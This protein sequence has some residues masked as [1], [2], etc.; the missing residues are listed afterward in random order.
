[1][2]VATELL[3]ADDA[4]R[5][6]MLRERV[7]ALS[8]T[9]REQIISDCTGDKTASPRA[10][11]SVREAL[12]ERWPSCDQVKDQPRGLR[13]D[14]L[15]RI[16]PRSFYIYGFAYDNDPVV[17]V[18][19]A[20]APDGT[21]IELDGLA[22]RHAH[23]DADGFYAAGQRRRES[24]F[25]AF[26][27]TPRDQL[28]DGWLVTM[29]NRNGVGLE[30]RAPHPITEPRAAC[31]IILTH[32][33]HDRDD[34]LLAIHTHRAIEALNA[35]RRPPVPDLGGL[36]AK[37]KSPAISIVIP[38]FGRI[39]L[40]EHQL[41]AFADD[42]DLR[43]VELICVLDS[44]ELANEMRGKGQQLH[45]L[46]HLP[47][48]LMLLRENRGF[49]TACNVG[50]NAARGRRIV[51]MHSDVVPK[52]HGWLTPMSD[53]L[54]DDVGVVGATLLYH[55]ESI[56][57]AGYRVSADGEVEQPR[58]G[59]HKDLAVEPTPIDAVSAACMMV[60]RD[61]FVDVGGMCD[62]FVD[63]EYEDVDLCR[64]LKARGLRCHI[65]S[66]AQLYHL[67]G[68][69]RPAKQR[70][71]A[72]PYNKWLFSHRIRSRENV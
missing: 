43:D 49:A 61:A 50:A 10:V 2:S 41:A 63:G 69:S 42:P 3:A 28:N 57:H 27:T 24:G 5:R 12:R 54:R 47:V 36:L 64:R 48:M 15:I 8:A 22:F 32:F 65:A 39:D 18:L 51:F 37:R 59:L 38:V 35:T 1:M 11:F 19:E 30:A 68:Q 23:D 44:P 14:G 40:L 4:T 55:D 25:I 31:N 58:K 52:S 62:Q 33:R 9:E 60:N 21:R 53:A 16:N 66:G 7:V 29:R 46:Y 20:I 26:V 67:E 72:H 56:Q 70:E 13:V 17:R 71:L 6:A 45:E 34:T